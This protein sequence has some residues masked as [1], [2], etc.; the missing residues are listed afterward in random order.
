[1]KRKSAMKTHG[2]HGHSG[3]DANELRRLLYSFKSLLPDL[4][5]TIAI[6]AIC[7]HS[8]HLSYLLP[9]NLYLL[10]DLHKFP[11]IRP[12]EVVEVHGRFTG[13]IFVKCAKVDLKI[14]GG[15]QQLFMKDLNIPK[16][17]S[18]HRSPHSFVTTQQKFSIVST[19]IMI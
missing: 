2:S 13:R 11:R 7:T 12:I 4:Y 8:S 15:E 14:L 19:V 6:L 18:K 3:M 16:C 5:R 1:M 17:F 10:V 9:Y